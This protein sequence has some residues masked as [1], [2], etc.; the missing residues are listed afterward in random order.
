MKTKT[1]YVSLVVS[2]AVAGAAFFLV[3]KTS[4]SAFFQS[5]LAIALITVIAIVGLTIRDY[6]R[7][8]PSLTVHATVERPALRLADRG[9]VKTTA[10]G[11]KSSHSERLAA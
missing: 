7:R 10:Y 8:A 5:D 9:S 2:A 4:F 1:K 11:I 6:S 3:S